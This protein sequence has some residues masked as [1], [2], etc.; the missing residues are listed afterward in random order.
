MRPAEAIQERRQL[1]DFPWHRYS[2]MIQS[3]NV[4]AERNCQM[5]H[6][7]RYPRSL[8]GP[9]LRLTR[10]RSTVVISVDCHEPAPTRRTTAGGMVTAE[11]AQIKSR[12][13]GSRI[14]NETPH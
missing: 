11:V 10:R 8:P 3:P 12:C 9:E 14:D 1:L 13:W 6:N 7:L 5:L 4:D 2:L